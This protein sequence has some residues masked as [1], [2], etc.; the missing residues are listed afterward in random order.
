M[1]KA[2]LLLVLG[3]GMI[4]MRQAFNNQIT[5]RESRKDQVDYEYEVLAREIARSG[6][7]VAMGIARE[8]PNA[9]DAAVYS[10]DV[11]DGTN[12]DVFTGEARGGE[13]SVRAET[14][15]GHS[16]QV[17]STG[18]YGGSWE[19]DLTTPA[20]NDSVY[21]GASYTMSDK[22]RI[23][24]MEVRTDGMLDV[25]FL[26]SVAGYC[27]AVFME[28]WNDGVQGETRMIFPSGHN[29]DGAT[30]ASAFYV[31]AG[32]QLNF[33]IGVDQNCTS[34]LAASAD[35]CTV[36]SHMMDYN[37]NNLA[38][39]WDYTHHALDIPEGAMDQASES[40][41]ALV[42]QKPTD[43]QRWRIAWEDI[44]DVSWDNPNST[45]P[46]S[47]IQAFKIQG[48]DT[49]ND[50]VGNGWT[51]TNPGDYRTLSEG[52]LDLNDQQIE[53]AIS[54]ITSIAQRD[55]VWYEMKDQRDDCGI[56]T[57]TGM[58]PE[59]ETVVCHNGTE[60]TVGVSAYNAH[61]NH[62]DTPGQ[63]PAPDPEHMVC[64]NDSEIMVPQS[65][66]DDH[67]NHGDTM[68]SCPEPQIEVCHNNEEMNVPQ[69]EV[70]SHQSHGDT[71]GPCPEPSV[72]VCHDGNERTVPQSQAQAHFDHGDTEGVCP[73][74][75]DYACPC[76]RKQLT[77]Q[78]KVGILHRPPGNPNNERLLCISRRGWERGHR[79]RHDD[80][81]ICDR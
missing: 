63:C 81:L 13:Y 57:T 53:V 7:N 67:R 31:T 44:H 39:E 34:E 65:R 71:V 16:L 80:L 76:S 55:S 27:S 72:Q 8:H 64:H 51:R 19:P 78:R 15:S 60:K 61:I 1:G 23:R 26:A 50:G 35:D 52:G 38:T 41:W 33:F 79:P 56:T 3:A 45:D 4:L 62:G 75:T 25:E 47:S 54:P 36:R 12:N 58:P 49:D 2:I 20:P 28:E 9:I 74:E 10:I 42:E 18:Y 5:E 48:Y 59:P 66:L 68:G 22:Y 14:I 73:D 6:F 43:R 46:S 29:R 11:A 70:A 69:S 32:T 77:K 24:V 21:T 30:P 17:T 37:L 40:I